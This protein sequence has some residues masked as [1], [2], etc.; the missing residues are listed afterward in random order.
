MEKDEFAQWVLLSIVEN[1]AFDMAML[2]SPEGRRKISER[3][4]A[5]VESFFEADPNYEEE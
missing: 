2:D 1:K 5:T 4:W 3:A